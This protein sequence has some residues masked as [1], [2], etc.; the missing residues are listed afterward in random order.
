MPE[1]REAER[2]IDAGFIIYRLEEAGAT[3]LALP[4]SG[5]S[6]K[7]RVSQLE[8][9]PSPVE[10]YGFHRARIRP[11]TPSAARITRMD[12]ALSWIALIPIERRVIRRIVGA[13]SL[14]SPVTERHL[15]SWRRLGEVVGADHKAVQR[16][17]GQGI[18]MLVAAVGMVVRSAGGRHAVGKDSQFRL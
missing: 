1:L 15:F 14:V 12:E 2:A 4:E 17:H 8:V 16:W 3:L 13:R 18:D 9:A 7:L 6:T 5:Y 11:P 10:A